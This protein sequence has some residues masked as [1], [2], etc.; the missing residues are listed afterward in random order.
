MVRARSFHPRRPRP[1]A[2]RARCRRATLARTPPGREPWMVPG[3]IFLGFTSR[4]LARRRAG[5]EP[6]GEHD[7]GGSSGIRADRPPASMPTRYP[8]RCVPRRRRASSRGLRFEVPR[9]RHRV[10]RFATQ[11]RPT[12][13]GPSVRRRSPFEPRRGLRPDGRGIS[14]L[15]VFASRALEPLPDLRLSLTRRFNSPSRCSRS[16]SSHHRQ[17]QGRQ[18]RED[19]EGWH[20]DQVQGSL[21]QVPV[22]FGGRRR[23]QGEQAQAVPAPRPRPGEHLNVFRRR[24]CSLGWLTGR[25][26]LGSGPEGGS[27]TRGV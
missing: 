16:R 25:A 5:R 22:Y 8:R 13:L 6:G 27:V 7:A 4:R 26:V 17:A 12:G 11:W 21:Q 15:C 19:Q 10:R 1:R 23:Q 20:Q 24:R 2:S 14:S 3:F 9:G 18:E